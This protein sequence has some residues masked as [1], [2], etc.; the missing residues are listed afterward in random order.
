MRVELDAVLQRFSGVRTTS[1][2]CL[3][4]FVSLSLSFLGRAPSAPQEVSLSPFSAVLNQTH[5][6]FKKQSCRKHL[7]QSKSPSNASIVWGIKC[8]KIQRLAGINEKKAWVALL[9]S[10]APHQ[11]A[12]TGFSQHSSHDVGVKAKKNTFYINSCRDFGVQG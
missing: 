11:G 3:S 5:M 9:S 8:S 4:L 2:R 6:C 12:F 1:D 10:L 7:K